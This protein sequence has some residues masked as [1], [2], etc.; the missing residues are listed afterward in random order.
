MTLG[1]I[2]P[3]FFSIVPDLLFTGRWRL[4]P[5]RPITASNSHSFN[6][7]T[8]FPSFPLR[9]SLLRVLRTTPARSPRALTSNQQA[10]QQALQE[11]AEMQGVQVLARSPYRGNQAYVTPQQ[12]VEAWVCSCIVATCAPNV[13][14]K[15]GGVVAEGGGA[16][17]KYRVS[18][19]RP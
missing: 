9:S 8:P 1:G 18:W 19:D 17:G 13:Y 15:V 4:A 16:R 7:T 11:K 12:P 3:Y 6:P 14:E 2:Y 10:L 5:Q